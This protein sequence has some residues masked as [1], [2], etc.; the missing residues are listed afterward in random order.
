MKGTKANNYLKGWF[1]EFEDGH[2]GWVLS[3]SAQEKRAMIREH[4][5]LVKWVAA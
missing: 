3:L 5:K 1:F 2:K 4:G